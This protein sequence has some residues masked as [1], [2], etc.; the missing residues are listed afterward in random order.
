M[1]KYYSETNNQL[2]LLD[3]P[4]NQPLVWIDMLNPTAEEDQR[5]EKLLS[6]SIPTRDEMEEI[7]LSSRLY[8][9]DDAEF[10]T[11]TSIIN[12]DGDEPTKTPI[13]FILKNKMLVTVR[14]VEP[15]PFETYIARAARSHTLPCNSGEIVMLGLLEAI[16]D[17]MAD[18]LER[19]A[20]EIDTFS[21]NIFSTQSKKKPKKS[22][23]LQAVI[24]HIGRKGDILTM[25]QECLISVSRTISYHGSLVENT[26]KESM[27]YIKLIQ[28]DA[29]SLGEHASFLTHKI[30]FLLDAT[31]GLINLEQNQIIKMFSVAAVVFLPPTLVASM[32]GMNF[33]HMPELDWN[34]GYP[35]ALCLMVVS[36]ILPYLYSKKRGWL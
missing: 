21:R 5:I 4:G 12:L 7:E 14:Y 28:R 34:L 8:H 15:K 16:S 10:M 3:N 29:A 24:E 23:D 13:T 17:R 26:S 6:I 19:V 33:K 1:L 36:A 31:L 25:I 11:I 2:V 9:E 32:Y 30:A 22:I 27:Q 18:V 20:N 35:M